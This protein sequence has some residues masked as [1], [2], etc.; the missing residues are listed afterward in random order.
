[1]RAVWMGILL[2]AVAV[3]GCSR[4]SNAVRATDSALASAVQTQP[5]AASGSISATGQSVGF[6]RNDYPGDDSMAAMRKDFAFTGYWLTTPPGDDTNT[7]T[8]KREL[9]KQQGWGFLVLANGKLEAEILKAKKAG[10]SPTDLGRKDAA[11]AIAAAKSEEFPAHTIV[12]LDQEEGGRLTDVQAAYLLAWT[13]AVAT[14]DFRPGVYASGQRVQDD[15][16]VWIDTVQDIRDRIKKGGLHEVAIFDAQDECSPA[17]GCTLQAKPLSEAGEPDLVAWQYSQSPRRP[18]IT[19][20]CAKT[21]ATDGNCY[22]PGFP[23]V[24]LDMNVANSPDPSHG[25]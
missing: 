25:R 1:M 5:S 2:G 4:S 20:S 6:D 16:G 10:T 11:G 9:L 23:K 15:P 17:P 21:Y 18:S 3:C 13:E 24:F 8:G 7:W 19:K 12:F 22:A 14:S